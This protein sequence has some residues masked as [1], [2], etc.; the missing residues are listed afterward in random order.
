MRYI[1]R[2]QK[3]ELIERLRALRPDLA[4]EG[5][6]H[7]AVFGSRARGDGRPGSDVDILI[8]VDPEK[9]FS[10]ID[11]IGVEHV[12]QDKTGIQAHAL[13]RRSLDERFRSRIE[14][15]VVEVF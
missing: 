4:A 12:I 2:M 8:D 14:E 10:L 5:V 9:L 7:L 15:D 13:M 3:H 1:R 6:E 11:L